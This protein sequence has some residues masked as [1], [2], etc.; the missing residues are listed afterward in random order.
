M[1]QRIEFSELDK[2]SDG[3]IQYLFK[4]RDIYID[5]IVAHDRSNIFNKNLFLILLSFDILYQKR[6]PE[7]G[8]DLFEEIHLECAQMRLNHLVPQVVPL[9]TVEDH[10]K[11]IRLIHPVPIDLFITFLP[12]KENERSMFFRIV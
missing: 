5:R 10:S 9:I 1:H 8:S 6:I 12:I 2:I 7:P 3:I 11:R 4:R